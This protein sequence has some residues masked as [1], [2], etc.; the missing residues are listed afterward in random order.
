MGKKL[1][2]GLA[3]LVIVMAIYVMITD[4]STLVPY[5]MFIVGVHVLTVG[6]TEIKKDNKNFWGYTSIA[7]AVFVFFVSIYTFLY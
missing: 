6:I 2:I 5:L 4:N 1:K 3:L 7:S